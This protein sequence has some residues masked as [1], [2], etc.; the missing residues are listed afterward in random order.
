MWLG[1][2]PVAVVPLW[3]VAHVPAATFAW[4][5]AA[6]RNAVVRWHASHDIEVAT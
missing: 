3:Q 2:L 6:G 4:L 1:V 5:K